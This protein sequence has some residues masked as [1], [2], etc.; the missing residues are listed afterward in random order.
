MNFAKGVDLS[1]LKNFLDECRSI[2]N[3]GE[4]GI[5]AIRKFHEIVKKRDL[6]I[7]YLGYISFNL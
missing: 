6:L 7:K 1:D 4:N 2:Y 3:M 5:R